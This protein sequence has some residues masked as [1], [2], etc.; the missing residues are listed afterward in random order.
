M[1]KILYILFLFFVVSCRTPVEQHTVYQ[2]E[3]KYKQYERTEDAKSLLAKATEMLVIN[4]G[5]ID[6]KR[7]KNILDTTKG[8][9][10]VDVNDGKELK[11]LNGKELDEFVDSIIEEDDKRKKEIDKLKEK[12]ENTVSELVSANIKLETLEKDQNKR[13]KKFYTICII[14]IGIIT[15]IF[16]FI[17]S[18][19]LSKFVK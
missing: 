12:D 1:K 9:L 2:R 14:I 10:D 6:I 8:L 5:T 17:P 16:Y 7:I 15:L 19:F 13:D 3:I 11:D 18:G 4:S